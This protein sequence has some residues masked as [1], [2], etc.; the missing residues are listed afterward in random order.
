MFGLDKQIL[1]TMTLPPVG[2]SFAHTEQRL[3]VSA[4]SPFSILLLVGI[5]ACIAI[6]VC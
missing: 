3:S 1:D 5:A 6:N 4:L 2:L